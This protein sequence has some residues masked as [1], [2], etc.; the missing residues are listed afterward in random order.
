MNW[1]KID[2]IHVQAA[3]ISA[4]VTLLVLLINWQKDK[5]ML[6]LKLKKEYFF[7]QRKGIKEKL[8]QSKT[9]LIKATEDL[10]QRL[11]NFSENYRQRQLRQT[12]LDK[13]NKQAERIEKQHQ[14]NKILQA[15]IEQANKD[16][17]KLLEK[18]GKKNDK[19]R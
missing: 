1:L 14:A 15:K 17:E 9:R 13:A 4:T 11:W 16:Y 3:I 10:N 19:N 18:V 2:D 6:N 5:Y 7:N 8:A 12:S